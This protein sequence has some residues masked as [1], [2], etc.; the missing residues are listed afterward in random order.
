MLP[1]FL[2]QALNSLAFWLN[3]HYCDDIGQLVELYQWL[4]AVYVLLLTDSNTL[5]YSD[6]LIE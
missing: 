4:P 2:H 1:V 6:W 3:I 5:F